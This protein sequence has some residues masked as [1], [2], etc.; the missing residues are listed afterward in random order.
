[1]P[2][3]Y[4]VSLRMCVCVC[5]YCGESCIYTSTLVT[6]Q[7][8]DPLYLW[9]FFNNEFV[10]PNKLKNIFMPPYEM[11]KLCN[12][13]WP[14]SPAPPQSW[15][16]SSCLAGGLGWVPELCER[17]SSFYYF[18][19]AQRLSNEY[20]SDYVLVFTPSCFT[21]WLAAKKTKQNRSLGSGLQVRMHYLP[22]VS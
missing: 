1:M 21:S 22:C 12:P 20:F 19:H 4:N 5:M 18:S 6:C 2:S 11:W 17:A 9:L 14:H 8:Y 13:G 3:L 15:N 7:K 10:F 16:Y